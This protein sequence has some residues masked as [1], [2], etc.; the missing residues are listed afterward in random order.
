MRLTFFSIC[1]IHIFSFLQPDILCSLLSQS[2]MHL[3]SLDYL[4]VCIVKLSFTN[5]QIMKHILKWDRS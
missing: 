4:F 1:P 5:A 3:R 2:I